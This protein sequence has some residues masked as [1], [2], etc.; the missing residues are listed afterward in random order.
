MVLLYTHYRDA[1]F[2]KSP[3]MV[4]Q[5]RIAQPFETV[6]MRTIDPLRRLYFQTRHSAGNQKHYNNISFMKDDITPP[7]LFHL[8]E[9]EFFKNL[10]QGLL[11]EELNL[12]LRDFMVRVHQVSAPGAT[13]PYLLLD[14]LMITQMELD[15]IGSSAH[16]L[17][18]NQALADTVAKAHSYLL[19]KIEQVRTTHK[20]I[21]ITPPEE[22]ISDISLK[23][24][25]DKTS[26]VELVHSLELGQ[27]FGDAS[28]ATILKGLA[29]AC[30]VS[31]DE[32][33]AN[34]RINLFASRGKKSVT[35]TLDHMRNCVRRRYNEDTEDEIS[36]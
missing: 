25:K 6:A 24:R 32:A 2:D 10:R 14:M 36:A 27:Y 18:V 13:D 19:H 21:I 30:N 1:N 15:T 31:I 17:S 33:Y 22:S 8:T 16:R 7:D 23:W 20:G 4:T 34:N 11:T 28:R 9:T 3:R 29:K 26:F 5:T 12:Q 35:S